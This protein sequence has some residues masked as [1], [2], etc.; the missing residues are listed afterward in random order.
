MHSD[1]ACSPNGDTQSCMAHALDE[2]SA[3]CIWPQ[4]V[5]PAGRL[6]LPP[7]PLTDAC[8]AETFFTHRTRPKGSSGRLRR[9]PG[10][11][12]TSSA[13]PQ[14]SR[15]SAH[16]PTQNPLLPQPQRLL[17]LPGAPLLLLL[18]LLLVM[19]ASKG[20]RLGRLVGRTG[21]LALPACTEQ[22]QERQQQVLA[23]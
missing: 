8:P 6:A 1:V 13:K 18:L 4:Q 15:R 5:C 12:P 7:L 3:T 2:V 10:V 9:A 21:R 19:A 23:Q 22:Q 11:C 20:A 14:S 16:S 17:P